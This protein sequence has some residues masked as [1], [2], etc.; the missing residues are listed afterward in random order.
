[1]RSRQPKLG[2]SGHNHPRLLVGLLG[3]PDPRSGPS[4]SLFEEAEGMLQVQAPDVGTLQQAQ[5][6]LLPIGTMPP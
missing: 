6:R 5:V 3:V 1:M 2:E 4:Q